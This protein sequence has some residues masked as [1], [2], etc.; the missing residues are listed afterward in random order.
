[1]AKFTACMD[2]LEKRLDG[3]TKENARLRA[4]LR[5]IR[6]RERQQAIVDMTNRWV[7]RLFFFYSSGSLFDG[8]SLHFFINLSNAVNLFFLLQQQGQGFYR[9]GNR[10]VFIKPSFS[11][12]TAQSELVP[13]AKFPRVAKGHHLEELEEQVCIWF[14]LTHKYKTHKYTHKNTHKFYNLYRS[15]F[16]HT[17]G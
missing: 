12:R 1:M 10:N 16:F 5:A 11:K 6:E 9:K 3:L 2:R 15:S 17:T 7:F 4:E 14:R 8:F 13:Q